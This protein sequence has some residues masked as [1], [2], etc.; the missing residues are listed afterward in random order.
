MRSK[1]FTVIAVLA[2]FA[3]PAFAQA[4][5]AQAPQPQRV[6]VRGTIVKLE[7]QNLVLKA[8]N[9]SSVTVALAPNYAVRALVKKK[10]SDIKPGDFVGTT[11]VPGKDGK[12]HA[13][14]VHFFP[15]NLNL[16]ETQSPWDLA[17]GATMTNAHVDG[18]AKAAG[19]GVLSINYKGSVAKVIVDKKTQIVGPAPTPASAA[20]LKPGR[21]VFILATKAPD[22]ALTTA[23]VTVEKNG[24]KPPM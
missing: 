8:Q 21:A 22:G 24:V 15:A 14:E 23:N 18:V 4:P 10:L 17:P 2:A 12:L 9:G 7:G 20:D 19:G 13:V 1:L 6:N 16:P 11:S 3:M 5:Q